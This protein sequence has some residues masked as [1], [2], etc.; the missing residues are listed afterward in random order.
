MSATPSSVWL[1]GA[2]LA[3]LGLFGLWRRWRAKRT[4][5]PL[6]GSGYVGEDMARRLHRKYLKGRGLNAVEQDVAF[7]LEQNLWKQIREGQE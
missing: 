3:V 5:R 1:F 6:P 4:R 2:D 7:K